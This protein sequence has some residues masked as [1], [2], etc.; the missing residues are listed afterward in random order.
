[1]LGDRFEIRSGLLEITYD[2]GAKVLLQGP[3]TYEVESKTGGFLSVGKLTGKV[4]VEAAKGFCVRT[5]TAVVTD[6]GTEFG[7]EVDKQ[8]NTTSHVFRGLVKVRATSGD[9]EAE[10]DAEVLH[11]NQSVYV[12]AK[13]RN[14]LKVLAPSAKLLHF[15][16]DIPKQTVKT[17]DLVDV[18]AG[19][20]G[21]SG[22]RGQGINPTNGEV[23]TAIPERESKANLIGN[24]VYHRVP[25]IP[26]VDGVF[27]PDGRSGPVQTDSAG[28]SV[29]FPGHRQSIG[30]LCLGRRS[31]PHRCRSSGGHSNSTRRH[32]L[33]FGRTWFV[34]YARQ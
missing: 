24:G 15:E 7:V 11:A 8:G 23:S 29:R 4:E 33:R 5:P 13:G 22:R 26:L 3:V 31:D 17:F 14:R 25:S 12:V 20:D 27:I 2:T 34:V 1:M 6:L 18:V 32:R 28:L 30:R 10:G 16:R 19:G 21:F 9:G